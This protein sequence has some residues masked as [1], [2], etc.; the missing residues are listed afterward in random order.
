[1]M[2]MHTL[3]YLCCR[4]Y[5]HTKT[6]NRMGV[7]WIDKLSKYLHHWILAMPTML[8]DAEKNDE[9]EIR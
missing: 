7:K 2:K 4:G 3:A 8:A 6:M 9:S 1:M 5:T